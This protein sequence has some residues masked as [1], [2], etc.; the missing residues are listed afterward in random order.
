MFTT[1]ERWDHNPAG[2][3]PARFVQASK[4]SGVCGSVPLI[5]RVT[6]ANNPNS[7]RTARPLAV[8]SEPRRAAMHCRSACRK[9]TRQI[10]ESVAKVRI[11][12]SASHSTE[13]RSAVSYSIIFP[14]RLFVVLTDPGSGALPE[15]FKLICSSSARYSNYLLRV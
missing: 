3:I 13:A 11:E 2:R 1:A 8:S 10:S 7:S 9:H 14:G 4:Q 5:G 12:L 6:Q 15:L